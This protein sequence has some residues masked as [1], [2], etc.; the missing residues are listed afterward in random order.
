MDFEEIENMVSSIKKA[1][2]VN[3]S[4]LL[5]CN[6]P[7]AID[8]ASR[9]SEIITDLQSYLMLIQSDYIHLLNQ[10]KELEKRLININT[11][12]NIDNCSYSC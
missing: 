2:K 8:K 4:I 7:S 6:S 5:D 12:D 3:D 10:K 1:K 9:L 11:I